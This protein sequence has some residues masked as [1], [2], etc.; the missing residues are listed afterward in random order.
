MKKH[1]LTFQNHTIMFKTIKRLLFI[2]FFAALGIGIWG[3]QQGCRIDNF[4]NF[5]ADFI[6]K[7]KAE[8]TAYLA[9]QKAAKDKAAQPILENESPINQKSK[10]MTQPENPFAV[11]DQYARNVPKS[12]EKNIPALASYLERV[13][14]TDL[15]KTRAIFVWLTDNISYDDAGYNSK[16]YGDLSPEGVLKSKRAVCS[17]F[18]RLFVALGEEMQLNVR[19]ASGFAKGYGFSNGGSFENTNHAWNLVEINGE[20]K[21]FDATWGAG[22]GSNVN[23][24]LVSKKEF[25]DYWFDTNPYA[26]IFNHLPENESFALIDNVPNLY[27]YEQL[28]KV[29]KNYFERGFDPKETYELVLNQPNFVFPELYSLDTYVKIISMPK[30]GILQLDEAYYFELFVPKGKKVAVINANKNWTHFEE[31]DGIF[32]LN[33]RPNA[34]GVLRL[35]VQ[36]EDSGRSYESV[37]HYEVQQNA[38]MM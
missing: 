19:E 32:S 28:P 4:D 2:A 31:N 8:R 15:E 5:S 34:E 14:D 3:Y 35:S 24:Q 23:G 7:V 33:Y 37:V 21:L 13:A 12:A 18:S 20:W 25:D 29:R 38:A 22:N 26:F 30:Q 9:E 10:R 36:H 17:G 16:S 1:F 27:E 6:E 11:I